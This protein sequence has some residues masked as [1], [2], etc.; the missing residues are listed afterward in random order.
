MSQ[1]R[2]YGFNPQQLIRIRRHRGL[3]QRQLAIATGLAR[4]GIARYE[5]GLAEPRID[6]VEAIARELGVEPKVLF[7]WSS[8]KPST[9]N[10]PEPQPRG[11]MRRRIAPAPGQAFVNN[12]ALLNQIDL[13][14]LVE[15]LD[16]LRVFMDTLTSTE[17]PLE[18]D[19]DLHDR[20]LAELQQATPRALLNARNEFALS[21]DDLS[22]LSGL[23]TE[24]LTEIETGRGIPVQ[25][26]EILTLRETLGVGYDPRAIATRTSVLFPAKSRRGA[27]TQFH[28]SV[29]EWKTRCR[30]MP[31]RLDKLDLLL[32]HLKA[33]DKRL[34]RLEKRLENLANDLPENPTGKRKSPGTT[35]NS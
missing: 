24:R 16:S 21:L 19:Q 33:Q 30:R 10:P 29:Q 28:E 20:E 8:E 5:Q 13:G 4:I 26:A 9:E 12:I 31:N 1:P 6:S 22:N 17:N 32:Q 11:R 15:G 2:G 7:E 25:P 14:P 34:E 35:T 27:R 23:P 3:S 18:F